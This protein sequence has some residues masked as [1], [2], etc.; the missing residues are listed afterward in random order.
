MQ[1]KFYKLDENYN[2][3]ITKRHNINKPTWAISIGDKE[4]RFKN[5]ENAIL[6]SKGLKEKLNE[7]EEYFP[8]NK[9][10]ECRVCDSKLSGHLQD[11]GLCEKCWDKIIDTYYIDNESSEIGKKLKLNIKSNDTVTKDELIS[12]INNYVLPT[13][14]NFKVKKTSGLQRLGSIRHKRD[15]SE[16]ASLTYSHLVPL[17][18]QMSILL[19]EFTHIYSFMN[20][21]RKELK[22]EILTQKV[23]TYL[24][25]YYFHDSS[26][27]AYCIHYLTSYKGNVF[28][29]KDDLAQDIALDIINIIKKSKS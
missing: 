8:H 9:K 28:S 5:N 26:S 20:L 6:I 3:N 22:D 4:I 2:E 12:I 18:V 19:H 10:S 16:L 13:Y 7:Y 17:K 27:N 23:E 15:L 11:D 29:Y 25:N 21:T 1:I 24:Y 14:P